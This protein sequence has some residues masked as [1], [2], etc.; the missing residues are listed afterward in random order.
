MATSKRLS[1]ICS[2]VTRVIA[3]AGVSIRNNAPKR[4]TH[5]LAGVDSNSASASTTPAHC[6]PNGWKAQPTT[7][8]AAT[9]NSRRTLHSA[10]ARPTAIAPIP[11]AALHT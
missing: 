7:S 11:I 1:R 8:N 5:S 2:C 3:T 4:R 10:L 9:L 6:G